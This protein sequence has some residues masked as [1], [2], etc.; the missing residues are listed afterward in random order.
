M[1]K[2]K[3]AKIL[4]VLLALLAP[5][6]VIYFYP[7]MCMWR[8]SSLCTAFYGVSVYL[9]SSCVQ[10]GLLQKTFYATGVGIIAYFLGDIFELFMWGGITLLIALCVAEDFKW[11]G[12]WGVCKAIG[13]R[14]WRLAV[15]I[16]GVIGSVFLF[17]DEGGRDPAGGG[18]ITEQFSVFVCMTYSMIFLYLL[19]DSLW[20]LL[21]QK[22]AHRLAHQ[23]DLVA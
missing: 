4:T 7:N 1:W 12:L 8:Y 16:C 15:G 2:E 23:R 3:D 14:L 6:C 21:R 17:Y 10:K 20:I 19:Y 11:N 13:Y 9:A 18:D 22:L 5:V